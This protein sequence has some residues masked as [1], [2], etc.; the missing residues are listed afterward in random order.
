MF[1]FLVI[2]VIPG[3]AQLSISYDDLQ[4]SVVYAVGKL[5]QQFIREGISLHY[6]PWEDLED[7]PDILITSGNQKDLRIKN[8]LP[9]QISEMPAEAYRLDW[10]NHDRTLLILA[11]D[12]VGAMYGILEVVDQMKYH[13]DYKKITARSVSPHMDFRGIKFNLPWSPYRKSEAMYL[14]SHTCRDL[15]F[16]QSFL[17]MMAENRF[18]ALTLW[19]RHPFPYMIKAKNYPEA[20]PYS[21]TEME[22][23]QRFWKALFRMAR[24]RGID[25]YVVNWNI[26]V[27]PE[28]AQAYGVDELNNRSEIVKQYTRESVTQLINE[29]DDLTGLGIT[30]ADWMNNFGETAGDMTPQQREAWIEDAFIAGIK[31]ANRPVKFIHRSVLS[32]DPLEMRRVIDQADL[33]DPVLVEV[34]FNFSHAYST[35]KLALT[36]DNN[37]GTI[38]RRYWD[39]APTNYNIQWMMRNEDF[40]IL[41]W[42]QPD[43]IRQHII[44]NSKAF[45]NGYFIG[46]EGYIPALDYAT[47]T[48]PEK[49]WQ[50]GFEK[51]WLFYKMWGHLLFDPTLPNDLFEQF[52]ESR[53]GNGVGKPLLQS[54]IAAGNMPLRLASLFKSTWDFTLYSEGFLA[55]NP[56]ESDPRTFDGNSP[57]I[58]VNELIYKSTLD[59]DYVSIEDYVQ[60]ILEGKE[61]EGKVTPPDLVSALLADHEEVLKISQQLEGKLTNFS[62][63]LRS[64]I[65]DLKTWAHLSAYF[66]YKIHGGV[67]LQQFRHTG[68]KNRQTYAVELLQLALEQWKKVVELTQFRYRPVPHVATRDYGSEFTHF[69]WALFLPAVERDIN[70]AR[71][72]SPLQK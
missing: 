18:N 6:Y 11:N 27:S 29:Y 26:V 45:V 8:L 64:E 50:Y 69:S 39:P 56:S 21:P 33:P 17:D 10:A 30:L 4:E 35:T 68:D 48:S 51:Q 42:A 25:T 52:L 12:P 34:K 53:Y 66:A 13:H 54:Y 70:L 55:A 15:D 58:S 1:L 31:Q 5:N 43:F 44:E 41:R 63:A 32:A 16:W 28:F 61:F 36:H 3:R 59:P 67:S 19:N 20:S 2:M 37:S 40:F 9:L 47:V 71:E 49:T 72:A 60:G 22:E 23:W 24:I 38:D 7:Y 62:G 57:F 65:D 14:H 46:S